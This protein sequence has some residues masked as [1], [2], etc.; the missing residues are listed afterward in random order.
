MFSIRYNACKRNSFQI[1]VRAIAFLFIK[2]GEISCLLQMLDNARLI[3][4]VVHVFIMINCY[5]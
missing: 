3:S 4:F 1:S 2:R 5:E